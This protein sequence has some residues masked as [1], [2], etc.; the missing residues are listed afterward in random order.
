MA[1]PSKKDLSSKS[2]QNLVTTKE[3]TLKGNITNLLAIHSQ[4]LDHGMSVF[5]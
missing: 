1:G 2:D 5:E 3:S 4:P